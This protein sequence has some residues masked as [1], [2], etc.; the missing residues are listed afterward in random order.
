MLPTTYVS[1]TSYGA[2]ED[3]D[4]HYLVFFPLNKK[5]EFALYG[6]EIGGAGTWADVGGV[7][8][9]IGNFIG[10]CTGGFTGF[11]PG[12]T[13][14]D[15]CK[16][17]R[18][19]AMY[20]PDAWS[21]YGANSKY[22]EPSNFI[23]KMVSNS[24][25]L[26]QVKTWVSCDCDDS[27]T[28][29]PTTSMTFRG[30][31]AY[32][33]RQTYDEAGQWGCK[34]CPGV[35]DGFNVINVSTGPDNVF[36]SSL[37]TT[38]HLFKWNAPTW[39]YVSSMDIDVESQGMILGTLPPEE[40]FYRFLS[41]QSNIIVHHG[42]TFASSLGCCC[43]GCSDNFAAFAPTRETGNTVGTGNFYLISNAVGSVASGNDDPMVV[44]GSTGAAAT[45]RIW[46]YN[47]T[48]SGPANIPSML[49]GT[50]GT[51]LPLT[52]HSVPASLPL[53]PNA[54]VY[55]GQYDRS[56][57]TGTSTAL[58][59]VE[60]LSGGPIQVQHG[61]GLNQKFAGGAV[62]HAADGDQLGQEFWFNQTAGNDNNC[63][64]VAM[65]FFDVFCPKAGMSVRCVSDDGYS[66][67]YTTNAKD[68]VI[69][70]TRLSIFPNDPSQRN[71][72]I[73]VLANGNE[74]DVIMVM[75]YCAAGEKMYTSPFMVMGTHYE[76]I[77][78]PV[79]YIGQNFWITVLVLD[80]T[81]T[82]VTTYDGTTGFT[83]T[84]PNANLEST[85]L[86]GYTYDW[87]GT[88]GGSKIF[89]D[90][91]M[92]QLGINSIVAY[93]TIDGSIT[94]IA[95]LMVIGVDVKLIKEPKFSVQASGDTVTFNICWSNYSSASA[96][97]F[98]INDA[99]P[100]GTGY[101]PD[102][103][104][105]AF[106][107]PPTNPVGYSM[108]Y[109]TTASSTIPPKASW[110]DIGGSASGTSPPTTTTWLRWTIDEIGIFTSGC[111]CFRV[112][113]D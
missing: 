33:Y 41:S 6:L 32:A 35:G 68:Q 80:S 86:G 84:D 61:D 21:Q 49:R 43:G 67:T 92:S 22:P 97:Q 10:T 39:N 44:I 87:A 60:V 14:G 66:A 72:R 83:S 88:E 75:N 74:G 96:F 64:S 79:V 104:S 3:G 5:T 19:P 99:I 24:P 23:Y 53:L 55:G 45:Y 38:S 7:S 52:D 91:T 81:N 27:H 25:L 69:A 58:F 17:E 56:S 36:N 9:S 78:P 4:G 37:T 16:P 100:N 62:M 109:A 112:T 101:E 98:V 113:V 110:T 89:F 57:F 26:W 20:D 90:V 106:C 31:V 102:P 63:G 59:K 29:A 65:Y 28:Y 50:S 85:S 105:A 77:A 95:T 42:F 30:F 108:A 15:G 18:A 82:L 71:W 46:V 47:P 48:G 93:D 51:W 40:G 34:N 73:N 1:Y 12:V 13:K 111:L 107:D 11:S 94:G 2:M 54:H 103:A 8:P 76:I 70:F